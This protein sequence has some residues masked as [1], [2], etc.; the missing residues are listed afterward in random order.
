MRRTAVLNIVGLTSSLIG[1]HTQE[2]RQGLLGLSHEEVVEGVENNI[3]WPKKMDRFDYIDAIAAN[4]PWKN[5][6][7]LYTSAAADD[8]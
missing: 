8:T 2:V 1:E 6:C 4:G 3:F 7:L 5:V